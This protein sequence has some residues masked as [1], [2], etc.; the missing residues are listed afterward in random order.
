MSPARGV[1]RRSQFAAALSV[2]FLVCSTD[3]APVAEND[4]TLRISFE[5]TAIVVEGVTPRAR[6][7][8][9]GV[10]R[11]AGVYSAST[12]QVSVTIESDQGGTARHELQRS[13]SPR[14]IYVAV[15]SVRGDFVAASPD[16][17]APKVRPAQDIGMRGKEGLEFSAFETESHWIEAIC[18]RPGH[19]AWQ[20]SLM[21]DSASDESPVRGKVQLGAARMKALGD[22]DASPGRFRPHDVLIAIDPYKLTVVSTT[23]NE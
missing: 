20:L 21:D 7:V 22:A 1:L 8:L 16:G 5:S 18:V 3:A 14:S 23:V 9:F 6:V 15:D 11:T 19:G 13:I 4:R 10:E 2:V 12:L 17:T